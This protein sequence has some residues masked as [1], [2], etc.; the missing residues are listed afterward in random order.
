MKL[1][2]LLPA[3]VLILVFSSCSKDFDASSVSAGPKLSR[4]LLGGNVVQEFSY[5]EQG[6]LIKYTGYLLP[7]GIKSSE[8]VRYYDNAGKLVKIEDAVNISSSL[9]VPLMDLSY[10]ELSYDSNNK[11]K[12]TKSY[13]L[14]AGAY[15]YVSK[16]M[17]DYDADGRITAVTLYSTNNQAYAKTTYQYNAQNNIITQELFQYNAGIQGPSFRSVYE[18]DTRKNPFQNIWVMPF[19]ANPNNITKQVSTNY[20]AVPANPSTTTSLTVIKCYNSDGYPTLVNENGVDYVY[21]YK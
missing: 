1:R 5:D 4:I 12:E 3:F 2:S 14:N 8:S 13:H 16:S 6:R 18:H 19:G 15:Q 21:E 7:G 10:S 11:L 20:V 17:P 9:T